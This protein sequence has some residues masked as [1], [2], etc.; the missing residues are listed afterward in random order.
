[1]GCSRLVAAR[2][3]CDC[4]TQQRQK[5]VSAVV[6]LRPLYPWI[7]VGWMFI[8]DVVCAERRC[9]DRRYVMLT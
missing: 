7:G 1:M 3:R 8:L 5:I 6:E 2:A 4:W 9:D